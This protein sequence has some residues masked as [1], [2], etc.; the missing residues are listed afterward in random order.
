LKVI[1]YPDRG[2]KISKDKD[3]LNKIEI[4]LANRFI[5][6]NNLDPIFYIIPDNMD[7]L[8]TNIKVTKREFYID[9]I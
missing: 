4:I 9:E 8:I 6:N 7:S 3:R 2:Y 1:K 5:D